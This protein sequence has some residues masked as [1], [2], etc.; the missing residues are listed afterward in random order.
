MHKDLSNLKNDIPRGIKM[1]SRYNN[2]T[3]LISTFVVFLLL[4]TTFSN[5][6]ASKGLIS[7]IKEEI[8]G[9]KN[10]DI[11]F[12]DT[13]KEHS[14]REKLTGL[15]EKIK[16]IL[17]SLKNRTKSAS[18]DENDKNSIEQ[19]GESRLSLTR[20]LKS[21]RVL[22][23]SSSLLSFYTDYAGK[24]KITP[25]RLGAPKAID[26]DDDGDNDVRVSYSIY[27]GFE[28]NLAISFNVKLN[29]DR[30]S[31]F[32]D[33]KEYFEAY[34]QLN[35]PGILYANNTNDRIKF[36]YASE[37]GYEVPKDFSITYKYIPYLLFKE[38][39]K[40]KLYYNPGLIANEDILGLVFGYDNSELEDNVTYYKSQSKW[41]TYLDPAAKVY[42][43]FGGADDYVGREFNIDVSKETKATIIY[44]RIVN[45]S[46]FNAGLVIDKLK[47]FSF[48]MEVTPFEKG[49]G[50]IEYLQNGSEGT[51]VTLFFKKE[52]ATY[53][54]AEGIPPHVRLSW[55]PDR[56]GYV[57]LTTFDRRIKR[58]GVRDTPPGLPVFRTH[59]YLENLPSQLNF[60]WILD[61][62]K[63]GEFNVFCEQAGVSAHLISNDFLGSG[64]KIEAH[65]TSKANFDFSVFWNV[66]KKSF[67]ILR[68]SSDIV[69]NLSILGKNGTSFDF[70]AGINNSIFGPF[71]I[72]LDE[73]FNGKANIT[74]TAN[75]LKIYALD[76]KLKLSTG[77]TFLLRANELS[78]NKSQSGLR[79][80]YS[81]NKIDKDID[82]AVELE[83]FNGIELRGLV[84]GYIDANNNLVYPIPDIVGNGYQRHRFSV[85]TSQANVRYWISEDRASG[86]IE[87]SGGIV[88]SFNSIFERPPGNL[89][90]SIK[91]T[92]AFKT[93]Q[94]TLNISWSTINNETKLSINGSGVAS[95]SGFELNIRDK[96]EI[97]IGSIVGSFKLDTLG[98]K[99]SLELYLDKA[100][101][102]FNVNFN[103]NIPK[104]MNVSLHCSIS[105]SFSVDVSGYIG[106]GWS[107]GNFT[108]LTG[109]GNLGY[110]GTVAIYQ[111]GFRY[112]DIISAAV[113]QITLTG[114]I[115]ASFNLSYLGLDVSSASGITFSAQGIVING[116]P[117]IGVPLNEF[118]CG[119][120]EIYGKGSLELDF[121]RK[122]LFLK[123]TGDAGGKIATLEILSKQMKLSLDLD[124]L[125]INIGGKAVIDLNKSIVIFD[126]R[127]SAFLIISTLA[128]VYNDISLLLSLKMIASA[129][130]Y[131][132]YST[133]NVVLTL[134]QS[135][136]LEI[137]N[138]RLNVKLPSGASIDARWRKFYIS[139]GPGGTDAIVTLGTFGL[140]AYVNIKTIELSGCSLKF[141]SS[142]KETKLEING[143]FTTTFGTGA[144]GL[145]LIVDTAAPYLGI[146]L[147]SG[148]LSISNFKLFAEWIGGKDN[149][150]LLSMSLDRISIKASLKFI[151]KGN[152][153]E[154]IYISTRGKGDIDVS[155]L[156]FAAAGNFSGE[157]SPGNRTIGKGIFAKLD[158]FDLDLDNI[159]GSIIDLNLRKV[160]D[161]WNFSGLQSAD[162]SA[163]ISKIFIEDLQ[164]G[165][166][167]FVIETYDDI[168]KIWIPMVELNI[169]DLNMNFEGKGSISLQL[170]PST[171][172]EPQRIQM[173]GNIEGPGKL[174][175]DYLFVNY[176]WSVVIELDDF[177]LVGPTNY[178]LEGKGK[179]RFGAEPYQDLELTAGA[180]STWS[181]KILNIYYLIGFDNFEG[182]G[183]IS[184][185]IRT[186]TDALNGGDFIVKGNGKW[187]WDDLRLTP[188]YSINETT[189]ERKR[190]PGT[191]LGPG[192]FSGNAELRI[193]LGT[194]GIIFGWGIPEEGRIEIITYGKTLIINQLELSKL[195]RSVELQFLSE[196]K[197]E[198]NYYFNDSVTPIQIRL[199]LTSTLPISAT[200]R[201]IELFPNSQFEIGL[202]GGKI[203]SGT[204][205]LLCNWTDKSHAHLNIQSSGTWNPQVDLI[206]IK[207]SQTH[208]V[209]LSLTD[210]V[211]FGSYLDLSYDIDLISGT[212]DYQGYI[213]IDTNN[214]PVGFTVRL[215]DTLWLCRL[216]IKTENLVIAWN[217]TSSNIFRWIN[218][219]G[220]YS[221]ESGDI[222]IK[223]NNK[224]YSL[225]GTSIN[226]M[227]VSITDYN[228]T[229]TPTNMKEGD[230]FKVKV[231]DASTNQPVSGATAQYQYKGPFDI[232]W[233]NDGA[234]LTTGSDGKTNYFT[235]H[236]VGDASEYRIKV[237]ASGY[238]DNYVYFTVGTSS[239][240]ILSGI[241]TSYYYGP[242]PGATVRAS[243]ITTSTS[244][245]NPDSTSDYT[246]TTDSQGRYTLTLPIGNYLVTASKSGY[247]S[248]TTDI[249]ILAG[250]QSTYNFYLSLENA[251]YFRGYV[252]SGSQQDA[253]LINATVTA[254]GAAGTFTVKTRP[255]NPQGWYEMEVVGGNSYTLTASYPGYQTQTIANQL[256]QPG[257]SKR[258]DFTLYPQG[259]SSIGGKVIDNYG[260]P[261][262]SA[263]VRIGSITTTTGSNGNYYVTVTPGTYTITVSK[264]KF[265][266]KT[267]QVTVGNGQS[268]TQNFQLI[269]EYG[270]LGYIVGVVKNKNTGQGI[271]G[272][273]VSTTG[274]NG[275]IIE[276]Y[277]DSSG[278]YRLEVRSGD[279]N[280]N[281][282]H[283]GYYITADGSNVGYDSGYTHISW[284][285]GNRDN[286][287]PDILLTRTSNLWVSPTGSNDPNNDWLFE[288][289]AYDNNVN[290]W[291]ASRARYGSTTEW[292]GFLELTL[293]SSIKCDAI[294]FNAF[295][296]SQYVNKIDVDVYYNGA[297]H[298]VYEGSYSHHM[299]V[300]KSLGGEYQVTKARVRFYLK[301]CL[302]GT[303][304]QLY[305]F[306]FE[307]IS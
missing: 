145:A 292:T 91:G 16:N 272:V 81:V 205:A 135:S 75:T 221:R 124:L 43:T 136:N 79:C 235:A 207:N 163:T 6:V 245:G 269:P 169:T 234:P 141:V 203:E 186:A 59:A 151:V 112:S 258:I 184:I 195:L 14:L 138:F 185:G 289:S 122:P 38:K 158:S 57:D 56:E 54:Y 188:R 142:S 10:E 90:G 270:P 192:D 177:T 214:I 139:L 93:P 176:V 86:W 58:I 291:A 111:L 55:E 193:D 32:E 250:Q 84:I 189:G 104:L 202:F 100:K 196:G 286:T 2:L 306:A 12:R 8:E 74:F 95:L 134:A 227:K 244:G 274:P 131:I 73:L 152:K 3:K 264:T 114:D 45:E 198:I 278:R 290:T 77:A 69:I 288:A 236:K 150:A 67:G 223:L 167:S 85:H 204:L 267:A 231:E 162:A 277:T 153:D 89:I 17:N 287:A 226:T 60:S 66:T 5:I 113:D 210:V 273:K 80:S 233:W 228:G 268:V 240:G 166:G 285:V 160:G 107:D 247:K 216:R 109:G 211:L 144:S 263:T 182:D 275:G 36:G 201:K 171:N 261:L 260:C 266:T 276:V 164:V 149:N 238:D 251:A 209:I 183:D 92:V 132:Q 106:L 242:I 249:T 68:T 155:K 222:L 212:P 180:T 304:A 47:G 302:T 265:M 33:I 71:E 133:D 101:A 252:Y 229:G 78:F 63:N 254:S 256:I 51:N 49:G 303:T 72:V 98:K 37:K 137:D 255:I 115:R 13:I 220:S 123:F 42:I 215:F 76:T 25:L 34:L 41:I 130:T 298:D 178:H 20:I 232:L 224:W 168:E 88:V 170:T 181:S 143:E 108:Y 26:V 62:E 175:I 140:N 280:I 65:F 53:V 246:T 146:S 125:Q 52:N 18:P 94:D 70:S 239:Y 191:P 279:N 129:Q 259:Q 213:A 110:Q 199:N 64:T 127:T 299:W 293:S 97:S 102:S 15:R 4:S 126:G 50:R 200:F 307:K 156:T 157:L 117:N 103:I 7:Q 179:I 46:K 296:N 121:T 83:I 194:F 197:F 305:E 35:F 257:E 99:G 282:Q 19:G 262:G 28:K 30:L 248:E 24:E 148:E 118:S 22:K 161:K 190:D 21:F 116:L 217:L 165:V 208:E 159:R 29:I 253:V 218:K 61:F 294:K 301:G 44:E 295:Y 87:I 23:S 219:Q 128:A 120:I 11:S 300:T 281:C 187:K 39:P 271:G 172:S 174:F 206:Q 283:H 31:G 96:I 297:W 225:W 173:Q 82:L 9:I 230:K 154:S 241:V 40:H 147:D 284:V 237:S 1:R 243:R 119:L 105:T 27:I 48:E